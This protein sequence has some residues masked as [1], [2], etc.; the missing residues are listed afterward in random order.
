M[1][2]LSATDDFMKEG[3]TIRT[4]NQMKTWFSNSILIIYGACAISVVILAFLSPE[5]D[6]ACKKEFYNIWLLSII[7]VALFAAVTFI[8]YREKS[9]SIGLKHIITI[10]TLLFFLQL[11]IISLYYFKT[12]WDVGGVLKSAEQA[13]RGNVIDAYP[14]SR[15]PNNITLTWIFS[16]IFSFGYAINISEK[17]TYFLL[18][19]VQCL[20]CNLT[21]ILTY[22]A[23]RLIIDENA[24]V[25]A[26]TAFWALVGLSPWI[27][28]P[29]S[30]SWGLIFPIGLLNLYCIYPSV[31]TSKESIKWLF[32]GAVA[33]FGYKIKPQI[34]IVFIAMVMTELSKAHFKETAKGFV[35]AIV[36]IIIA[37]G[38]TSYI[39]HDFGYEVNKEETFGVSHFLAMGLNDEKNGV[40]LQDDVDYSASFSTTE[41]RNNADIKLAMNRIKAFGTIGLAKHFAK[42]TMIT[43]HD[44][45][46]AWG[47]EGTFL[48]RSFTKN[49]KAAEVVRSFFYTD[50]RLYPFFKNIEQAIWIAIIILLPMAIN[51]EFD[52]KKSVLMLTLVGVFAYNL[53][54]EARARYLFI[55]APFLLIMVGCAIKSVL[56][57]SKRKN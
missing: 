10:S 21:G 44:G 38:G 18:I 56:V 15:Y 25:V 48:Q 24:A 22:R 34:F 1:V 7:G 43:Y 46:F 35:A 28:I 54:F 3:N 11:W 14:F 19:V 12:G 4:D 5:K 23:S 49:S 52:E 41:D 32:I 20:L 16:K 31:K 57:Y 36:G 29:Y 17:H 55:F 30:D 27:S 50:G 47:E 33:F 39:V 26:F 9:I 2:V 8:C 13:A 6:F 37:I 40:Y 53:I 51:G 42:K 45:T